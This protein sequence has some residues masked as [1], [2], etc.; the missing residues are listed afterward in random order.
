MPLSLEE[1]VRLLSLVDVFESLVRQ[2][3]VELANRARDTRLERG[4]VLGRPQQEGNEELYVLKEGRVQLYVEIPSGGEVTLSVVEGGSIFGELALGG[5]RSGAVYAR[6]LVPSLV[7]SLKTQHVQQL[8]ESSPQVGIAMVRL[9]SERLREAEV[10]LAE[11][12]YQQVPARLA[13][14][15]LRLSATEGIMTREGIRIPTPYTHW[16]LA[17][18][19]VAKREAVS[20]ALG[21]L[22]EEDAVEVIG[23]RIHVKDRKALERA[24]EA[25]SAARRV[26]A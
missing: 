9:L 19:I 12:A 2:E 1:K 14:L 20:R 26:S 23:R 17:S 6:A 5:L 13:N 11:L 18:M 3:L 8:I 7:C 21:E 4:E 15:I 10:R 22:R 16:Q 25:R 24:A